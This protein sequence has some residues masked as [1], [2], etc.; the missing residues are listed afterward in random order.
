MPW[1]YYSLLQNLR[2]QLN[3]TEAVLRGVQAEA[4]E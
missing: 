4:L 2:Q 3:L 1:Q